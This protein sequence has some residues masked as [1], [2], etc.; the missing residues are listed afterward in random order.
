MN[1]TRRTQNCIGLMVTAAIAV[2]AYS[3]TRSH[4]LHLNFALTLLA[5]AVITS[6]MKVKL[7][8]ING[9]MSV[10]LPFLLTGIVNLSAAE[11]VVITLVSTVAQCWPKKDAKLKPQQVIFNLSMMTFATCLANLVFSVSSQQSAPWNMPFA[12]ALATATLLLGQ[13]IPVAAIIS[14]SEGKPTFPIFRNV[15]QLSFPYYVLSAGIVS[16]LEMV[17]IHMGWPLALIVF[18]VMFGIHASYRLY[19]SKMSEAVPAPVLVR[20][21]HA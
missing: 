11:A 8:G 7:P 6:R 10:N 13:T 20:A 16:M 19:F 15:V 2:S 3:V 17:G 14:V 9:N 5:L 18:P 12:L 1:H 21:A 4:S